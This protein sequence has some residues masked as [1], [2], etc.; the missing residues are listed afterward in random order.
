[1]HVGLGRQLKEAK[2]ILA[3][4]DLLTL[5]RDCPRKI[6]KR[7]FYLLP[8]VYGSTMTGRG[9]LL[10][11][12]CP[13]P[14]DL[15]FTCRH[16]K[17]GR[18]KNSRN[19]ANFTAMFTFTWPYH[20]YRSTKK[21]MTIEDTTMA[22]D[23]FTLLKP[24]LLCFLYQK[25]LLEIKVAK[26]KWLKCPLCTTEVT[27]TSEKIEILLL[28]NV[29]MCYKQWLQYDILYCLLDGYIWFFL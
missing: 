28:R 29:G 17:Y 14:K 25:G 26:P 18:T 27:S 10:E 12:K 1:M 21:E 22:M 16:F 6:Y 20:V 4:E 11:Q 8:Q 5:L 15:V 7:F 13:S 19:G 23:T 3:E 2:A 24:K 9:K